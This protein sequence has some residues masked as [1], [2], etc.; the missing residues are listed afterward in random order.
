MDCW[1]TCVLFH[2]FKVPFLL[3]FLAKNGLFNYMY[4]ITLD[5]PVLDHSGNELS[6]NM[7]VYYT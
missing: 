1:V 6:S 4:I 3:D 7:Y 2:L 5:Y